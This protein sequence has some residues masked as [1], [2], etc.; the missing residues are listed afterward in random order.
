M[1]SCTVLGEFLYGSFEL[2]DLGFSLIE[3]ESFGLFDGDI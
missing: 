3:A 2:M 1:T